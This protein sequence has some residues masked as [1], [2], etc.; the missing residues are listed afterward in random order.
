M[1]ASRFLLLCL[2]ASAC[3]PGSGA[4]PAQTVIANPDP[5]LAGPGPASPFVV[6]ETPVHAA[7]DAATSAA[8]ASGKKK[9]WPWVV[10]GVAAVVLVIVLVSGGS[11]VGGGY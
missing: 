10:A 1:K 4:S 6:H 8:A 7:S 9:V 5:Q 11:G 2:M 3:L